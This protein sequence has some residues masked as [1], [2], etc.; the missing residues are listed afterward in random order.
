METLLSLALPFIANP[1]ASAC[2]AVFVAPSVTYHAIMAISPGN[3]Q[4]Q[5]QMRRPSSRLT[6]RNP[7]ALPLAVRESLCLPQ[8]A[9]CGVVAALPL[10]RPIFLQRENNAGDHRA[11]ACHLSLSW[12][13][14]DEERDAFTGATDIDVSVD[15][16]RLAIIHT[17]T[18]VSD[19]KASMDRVTQAL[20][21]HLH[22][23]AM[24]HQTFFASSS[25]VAATASEHGGN[26][27]VKSAH[28]TTPQIRLS[29]DSRA[30]SSAATRAQVGDSQMYLFAAHLLETYFNNNTDHNDSLI[31]PSHPNVQEEVRTI[32]HT[33]ATVTLI[34]G[35][36]PLAFCAWFALRHPQLAGRVLDRVQT[37]QCLDELRN[38]VV[39]CVRNVSASTFSVMKHMEAFLAYGAPM[40]SISGLL[41][42][43]RHLHVLDLSAT[44]ITDADIVIIAKHGSDRITSLALQ[45]CD[46][47]T[48]I[49]ALSNCRKLE[50]LVIAEC[51]SLYSFGKV[52]ATLAS[53]SSSGALK[54]ISISI[55][56]SSLEADWMRV[57]GGGGIN[58]RDDLPS[59]LSSSITSLELRTI[60]SCSSLLTKLC[61][62]DRQ[63]PATTME[64]RWQ[65]IVSCRLGVASLMSTVQS[66]VLH[67]IGPVA[68]GHPQQ[69]E[70]FKF[71]THFSRLCSFSISRCS[72]FFGNSNPNMMLE[73]VQHLQFLTS[74]EISHCGDSHS[75]S[76]TA[77]A[78]LHWLKVSGFDSWRGEPRRWNRVHILG[79]LPATVSVTL[80]QHEIDELTKNV[81]DFSFEGL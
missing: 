75:L 77:F 69:D 5:R 76:V 32:T 41:T 61:Q 10:G 50:T 4:R 30:P 67:N 27:P 33:R 26:G 37:I 36:D 34:A 64:S 12:I 81:Y 3:T 23:C 29:I 78:T 51:W 13:H 60:E 52:I 22:F 16:M 21:S 1:K 57:I 38:S 44:L 70:I 79:V 56:K 20:N 65:A 15:G 39:V 2:L 62:C 48:S 73:L 54:H 18:S 46:R 53:S 35:N 14:R 31:D 49:D 58:G 71:V 47:I 40:S 74:L 19:L 6:K 55:L 68:R 45:E 7:Y 25:L 66:L 17:L 9:P 72:S 8:A 28:S 11:I 59:F 80:E 42:T 24:L 43:C 63:Q